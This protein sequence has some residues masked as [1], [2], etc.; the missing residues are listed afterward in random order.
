MYVDVRVY[1]KMIIIHHHGIALDNGIVHIHRE[2]FFLSPLHTSILTFWIFQ[3]M[4]FGENG[5]RHST[6]KT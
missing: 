4:D 1:N 2:S 5:K 3:I 6:G